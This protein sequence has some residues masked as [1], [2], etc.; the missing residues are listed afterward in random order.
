MRLSIVAV[1]SLLVAG[2]TCSNPIDPTTATLTGTAAAVN[3]ATSR[4]SLYAGNIVCVTAPCYDYSVHVVG[5]VYEE[6]EPGKYEL[7]SL[8]H[9]AVGDQLLVWQASPV[10]SDSFPVG[11]EATRVVVRFGS[12]MGTRRVRR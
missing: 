8:D 11:V 7:I 1:L 3:A 12:G 5:K 9:V 10:G 6:T 2:A 4:I